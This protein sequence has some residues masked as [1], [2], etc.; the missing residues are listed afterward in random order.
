MKLKNMKENT[1][2]EKFQ[3]RFCDKEFKRETS[4]EKHM[5]SKKI[6]FQEK[7]EPASRIAFQAW[8][9]FY[10]TNAA[11]SKQ[12][13]YMDFI[14][15]AYYNAFIKFGKYCVDVK[16]V[17]PMF[18]YK[19]LIDNKIRIDDWAKDTYYDRYLAEYLRFEDPYDALT[20]SITN[21][22]RYAEIENVQP[23]DYL[24]YGNHNKICHLISSG[25]ISPWILYNSSSGIHFLENIQEGL[26]K[27]ILDYIDPEKW[28]LIFHRNKEVVNNIQ[29]ILQT[30][31]Y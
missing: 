25:K 27:T 12:K 22:V 4:L 26:Q 6:R 17:N 14:K 5:C 19:W 15:S 13:T 18:Y 1:V 7:N 9:D 20:R 2:I 24:R 31:N 11:Y 21:I 16:C 23:N 28:A 30:G 29:D 8:T 10:K 3:C